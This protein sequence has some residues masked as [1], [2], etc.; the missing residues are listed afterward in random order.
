MRYYPT[1]KITYVHIDVI[2]SFDLADF[3]AY[4]TSNNKGY[5]FIFKKIDSLSKYVWAIP[6]KIKDSQTITQK[7][8]IILPTSER[9]PIKM[10][11]DCGS[12]WYN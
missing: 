11:S 12:E 5:R 10:E 4:K 1:N 9:Q 8:S 3:S 2:W 6:L 7:L